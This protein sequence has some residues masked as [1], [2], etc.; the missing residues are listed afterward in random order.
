MMP[1]IPVGEPIP[2]NVS[3]A[4]S[5]S[6]PKWQDIVDYE[7]GRLTNTTQP[8]QPRVFIQHSIQTLS[9]RLLDNFAQPNED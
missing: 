6:L 4:V 1:H 2:P 5:V 3:H 9:R 7:E 8:A